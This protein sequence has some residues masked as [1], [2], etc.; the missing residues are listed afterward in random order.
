[1]AYTV[2]STPSAST[3]TLNNA[4]KGM[5]EMP[6]NLREIEKE[7]YAR[8]LEEQRQARA[9]RYAD[10][11]LRLMDAAYQDR[12]DNRNA[13]AEIVNA[14]SGANGSS[15]ENMARLAL[16][17]AKTGDYQTALDLHKNAYAYAQQQQQIASAKAAQEQAD[18]ATSSWF[19]SM[20]GKGTGNTD[21]AFGRFANS[22]MSGNWLGQGSQVPQYKFML[23]NNPQ[24]QQPTAQSVGAW[25][26]SGQNASMPPEARQ[27]A[28]RQILNFLP[29]IKSQQ[30]VQFGKLDGQPFAVTSNGSV[31]WGSRQQAPSQSKTDKYPKFI[32]DKNGNVIPRDLPV[33]IYWDEQTKSMKTT[34]GLNPAYVKEWKRLNGYSEEKTVDPELPTK[35]AN[36]I[37]Q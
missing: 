29:N 3:Q 9:D 26:Y 34:G 4:F 24:P 20:A 22:F 36:R 25:L 23:P 16:L 12:I 21:N 8:K 31:S 18:K 14:F 1:M 30:P 35:A 11:Q 28:V 7:E 19:S 27:I 33:S 15:P 10:A 2:S 5:M 6:E 32:E 13:R 37:K 17:V